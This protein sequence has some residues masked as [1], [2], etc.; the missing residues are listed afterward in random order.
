V[1][2]WIGRFEKPPG[3]IYNSCFYT[4]TLEATPRGVFCWGEAPNR[5]GGLIHRFDATAE[6]WRPVEVQ[7]HLPEPVVDFSTMVYDA[8][9]DRFLMLRTPY[10]KK[11]DGQVYELDL[12]TM[13]ARALDPVNRQ[14]AAS[15]GH[16]IDRACYV[17][18]ADLVLL[19]ALLPGDGDGL[20]RHIAYDG[21]GNRWV[22]L[23]IEYERGKERPLAPT[24]VHR[25]VG[26]VYDARRNRLWGVDTNRLRVFVLRFDPDKADVQPL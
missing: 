14:A 3:M 26:L 19:C 17:P 18:G 8:R 4:L 6:T 11:P 25:S 15:R 20:R 10:G 5:E 7:G 2:D 23:T 24:A 21:A 1:A 16:A 13:R 12:N 9:R 22:S